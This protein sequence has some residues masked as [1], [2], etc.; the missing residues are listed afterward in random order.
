MNIYA[1]L[2]GRDF[3]SLVITTCC[4]VQ[5]YLL[6]AQEVPAGEE[7]RVSEA[8]GEDDKETR[9]MKEAPFLLL[10]AQRSGVEL[11]NVEVRYRTYTAEDEGASSDQRQDAENLFAVSREQHKAAAAVQ[12]ELQT[13]RDLE[14]NQVATTA[15]AGGHRPGFL[16]KP[17]IIDLSAHVKP[18]ERIGIVGRTG[19]GAF[20]T[21]GCISSCGV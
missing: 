10:P 17:S 6:D 4:C 3:L 11:K 19:A 7:E 21:L 14:A 12:A 13:T 8:A 9:E 20:L 18:G 2:N 16:L 5:S 15:A 1:R